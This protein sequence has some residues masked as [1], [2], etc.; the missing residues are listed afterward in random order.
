M[1]FINLNMFS[2]F[3]QVLNIKRKHST[4]N[5]HF[6]KHILFTIIYL[7]QEQNLNH[8]KYYEQKINMINFV[9]DTY[10]DVHM[11]AKFDFFKFI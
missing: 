11:Y 4:K 10:H 8:N 7:S 3:I 2:D 9:Q 6:P 5:D 1:H